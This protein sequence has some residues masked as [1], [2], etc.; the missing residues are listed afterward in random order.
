MK[1]FREYINENN[2]LKVGDKLTTSV[3]NS[4]ISGKTGIIKSINDDMI[5]VDFGYGD[6]YGIAVSR[7][8]NKNIFK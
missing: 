8:K 5:Q 1:T 2:S 6:V 7:I 3:K 4:I